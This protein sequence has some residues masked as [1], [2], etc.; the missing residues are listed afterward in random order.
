MYANKV[1]EL[2]YEMKNNDRH[3]RNWAIGDWTDDSDQMI[4][5]MQ[6]LIDKKG[7]V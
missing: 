5:I 1:G 3:R 2:E 7:Q 4:L 6:S